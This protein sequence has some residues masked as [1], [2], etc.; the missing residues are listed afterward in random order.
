VAEVTAPSE[1]DP[2]SRTIP[3]AGRTVI[4]LAP[5]HFEAIRRTVALLFA[6]TH[7]EAYERA[8]D[9]AAGE[10]ERF[11]PGNF[12]V[13]MGYDFHVTPDGPRLIEINTNAGGALLNGLH[14]ASLCDP[15]KLACLCADLLPVEAMA[16]RIAASFARELEAA[17]GP[18]AAL[19]SL[20]ILDDRPR[21]QFLYPE[22]ELFVEL[23]RR[24]G[25]RAE[26]RDT[27]EF[28]GGVDLVYL[29]DTDFLLAQPRS[30]ALRAAY[31]GR[32]VVVT[33]APREH[34]LL[35]NKRR[36][37]LFSSRDALARLGVAPGDADFLAGVVPETL[38][39][40]ELGAGRA[41]AERD[42]WVFKPCAAFGSKAV[43]RGDK[44]SR[45]KLAEI[46]A[47]P[48]FVA[49]RRVD[50]GEVEVETLDG[51]R[52]M[53]FD[54][55]AYAYRGEILLLGARVYRGQVTNLRSPGGGFSAICVAREAGACT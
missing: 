51:P 26:I 15:A 43:Y 18:G 39:L 46:A 24:L 7:S 52:A 30:A 14:T 17:R 19:R 36:L 2:G 41:W 35:A 29:R 49:Q 28:A 27:S 33:P 12:G 31:L 1:G 13:F 16:D 55:R 48:S 10:V 54:V 42:R 21:E 40:A 22:F 47:D 37:A 6:L 9:A 3:Y 25:I 38:P 45:R 4:A 44:V 50:P 11:R 32:E 23:F 53:K 34:H 20:A 5:E 8:V